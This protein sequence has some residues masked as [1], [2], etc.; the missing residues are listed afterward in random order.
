MRNYNA[1]ISEKINEVSLVEVHKQTE[2]II[3]GPLLDRLKA[4]E[5]ERQELK[6]NLQILKDK[7]QE[8]KNEL[9]V[10]KDEIKELEKHVGFK[11]SGHSNSKKEDSKKEMFNEDGLC[12]QCKGC[13]AGFLMGTEYPCSKCSR[14]EN[15][16]H[17]LYKQ[18]G[19]K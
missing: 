1:I 15:G 10:L 17:D 3:S 4:L 16:T 2:V 11:V 12:E 19:G 6:C 9:Q 14:I 7:K 18:R 13:E 5:D 8:L